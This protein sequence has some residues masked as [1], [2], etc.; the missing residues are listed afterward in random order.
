MDPSLI[1]EI[2]EK[3]HCTAVF[4]FLNLSCIRNYVMAWFL[5]WANISA[6]INLSLLKIMGCYFLRRV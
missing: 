2:I 5:K 4:F 1:P 6:F 3:P